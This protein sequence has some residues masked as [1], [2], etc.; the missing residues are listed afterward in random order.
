[1]TAVWIINAN[2]S[3]NAEIV[4][5]MTLIVPRPTVVNM[6]ADVALHMNATA[7]KIAC[8]RRIALKMN[9]V[10]STAIVVQIQNSVTM[11]IL[12]FQISTALQ[13]M[14]AAQILAIVG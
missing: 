2:Q 5:L 1:M 8:Q 12:A 11:Y 13:S 3:T 4:A 7:R 14:N 6:M 10:Q 9:V